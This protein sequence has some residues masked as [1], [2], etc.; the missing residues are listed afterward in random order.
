MQ[1]D[2]FLIGHASP[3]LQMQVL[4]VR[5]EQHLKQEPLCFRERGTSL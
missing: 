5:I 1:V 3:E 4:V 2:L